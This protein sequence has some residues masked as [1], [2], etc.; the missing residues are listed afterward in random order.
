MTGSVLAWLLYWECVRSDRCAWR[1]ACS[2][3]AFGAGAAIVPLAIVLD[4]YR[5]GSWGPFIEVVFGKSRLYADKM[6]TSFWKNFTFPPSV[7]S[8]PNWLLEQ[9]TLVVLLVGVCISICIVIWPF[10]SRLISRHWPLVRAIHAG[11]R[12]DLALWAMLYLASFASS[13]PREDFPHL[14]TALPLCFATLSVYTARLYQVAERDFLRAAVRRIGIVAC[15]AFS[16]VMIGKIGYAAI[17]VSTG[18]VILFREY[19]ASGMIATAETKA[20][21]QGIRDLVQRSLTGDRGLLIAHPFGCFLYPYL[22]LRAP[23]SILYFT[24]EMLTDADLREIIVRIESG[25]IGAL[26]IQ[27]P[28][29]TGSPMQRLYAYASQS[30]LPRSSVS[31]FQLFQAP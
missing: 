14:A 24:D 23:T 18:Q 6:S 9:A 7:R 11:W 12:S 20:L 1:L 10:A 25:R 30:M 5:I 27:K 3:S 4:L 19:P 29:A 22:G 2:G 21:V 16:V 31:G 17:G 28:E 26:L 8:L 15:L 13:F